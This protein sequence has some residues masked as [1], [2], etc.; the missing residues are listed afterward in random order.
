MET[1]ILKKWHANMIL[2]LILGSHYGTGKHLQ[3]R[4]KM[5][6]QTSWNHVL[7]DENCTLHHFCAK[8]QPSPYNSI[9]LY[10]TR[11][12]AAES[13][14]SIPYSNTEFYTYLSLYICKYSFRDMSDPFLFK[15]MTNLLNTTVKTGTS[16]SQPC[17][18]PTVHHFAPNH[19]CNLQTFCAPPVMIKD[20]EIFIYNK[21]IAE[22]GKLSPKAFYMGYTN[23]K[24]YHEPASILC[25][26]QNIDVNDNKNLNTPT[27]PELLL[28]TNNIDSNISQVSNDTVY[29]RNVETPLQLFM[30]LAI[31]LIIFCLSFLLQL[32][33]V[34][35]KLIEKKSAVSQISQ[36]SKQFTSGQST[37][38]DKSLSVESNSPNND[39]CAKNNHE[40]VEIL[41]NEDTLED[42]FLKN[43]QVKELVDVHKESEEKQIHGAY[44]PLSCTRMEM[45]NDEEEPFS[46]VHPD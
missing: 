21:T 19:K 44:S 10:G 38:Q 2:V 16:F 15:E 29:G 18:F 7:P 35:R 40:N 13:I 31:V 25:Q 33:F 22:S 46:P 26:L 23:T 20:M 36:T 6:N 4:K 34:Y 24:I 37:E 12:F 14:T 39:K 28:L 3:T 8:P 1:T 45:S 17:M 11:R 30:I 27:R 42:T 9:M 41:S 32:W 5:C 43:V